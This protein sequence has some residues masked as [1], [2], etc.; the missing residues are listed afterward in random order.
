MSVRRRV[1]PDHVCAEARLQELLLMI[2]RSLGYMATVC[3]QLLGREFSHVTLNPAFRPAELVVPRLR[4]VRAVVPV[5]LGSG[6]G[7]YGPLST[8]STCWALSG[9]VQPLSQSW[10]VNIPWCT[11]AP[12]VR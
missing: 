3:Q 9:V 12:R 1:S 4:G 10:R 7:V 8:L 6:M 2:C 11:T 5:I